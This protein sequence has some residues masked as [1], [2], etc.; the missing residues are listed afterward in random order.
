MLH[1]VHKSKR[2]SGCQQRKLKELKR[3][4]LQTVAGTMLKYLKRHED[5]QCSSAEPVIDMSQSSDV[6]MHSEGD[7]EVKIDGNVEESAAGE[8]LEMG[9]GAVE[10]GT[11]IAAVDLLVEQAEMDHTSMEEKGQEMHGLKRQRDTNADTNFNTAKDMKS[12]SNETNKDIDTL[13][14]V[15]F[16]KIPVTSHFRVAIMLK[17]S[18]SFQ[19]KDGP[20][21][22]VTRENKKSKGGVR[23][24]SKEWFYKEMPNGEKILRSWMVYSTISN[25]LYCFCCRLFAVATTKGISAF[26]TGFQK[27]WKLSPKVNDHENSEQHINCVEKWKTL[28]AGLKLEKTIDSETVRVMEAEKKRW[29]DMLHRLL[30]ITLFLAKQ[31][32]PFRGHR[33]SESSLNKG[34]FLELVEMLSK[35]DAVL[36]EHLMRLKQSTCKLQSAVTYLAPETQN[37]FI[38]IL[39]NQLKDKLVMEIKAAK[40]FAIMFD[41]TPDISQT[42]QMSE[43]IRYVKI[44][45]RTAEVKE[46]FLGF[47]QTKSKKAVDLS[48]DIVEKLQSDGLDI[49]MCRAQG[50]DNA[51][52]MAG[53]HGGVQAIL[54]GINKKLVFNGCVDH[55]LNLCGQH[56]FAENASCVTFFGTL[57]SMYAFFAAST[58]RWDVLIEHTAVSLKRLSTTRWS[59]H[60][61]AVKPVKENFDKFVVALEALCDQQENLDTRAAARSLLPAVCD[62]TFLCYLYFWYGVLHEV[63][64]AQVYLQGKALT[65]DRVIARLQALKFFLHD[66]CRPLVE[67][68]IEQALM[69]SDEHGIAVER[70]TRCK[71]MMPGERARDC[72]LPLKEENKR[73]MIECI[74]RFSTELEIRTKAMEELSVIFEAIQVKSLLFSSE[75]DLDVSIAN[76]TTV[77]DEVLKDALLVEILRLRRFLKAA[78]ID[79][80]KAKSW[81]VLDILNFIIEWD[82]ADSLPSLSLSLRLFLTICVSVASCERSFSKLKLIKSYLRS[83]MGQSRLTNLALL[84]IESEIAETMDFDETIDKF[85][86]V[87]ARKGKF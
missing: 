32:L 5:G 76:L 74:D 66:D 48:H 82:F 84:S 73:S 72:G 3:K 15:F 37:E 54:K 81:S 43:V 80:E 45:S 22:V 53:I 42:D 44:S 77:Y 59:A 51:A 10:Q 29:R 21:A 7:D 6:T 2:P 19:N 1:G 71:K 8:E 55:S 65:L 27:W 47:F 70:R 24:L 16:W 41:S 4:S 40:Y 58:H 23:Q 83:T 79:M 49:M 12:E 62:F 36:K 56:S 9:R 64:L 68:A 25:K 69:K 34:N 33:E 86:A 61:F 31:N 17:G 13:Q 39:A 38:D 60:Y 26:V 75:D 87:K 50:Y 14:D 78:T 35:Y 28:A 30:D 11:T 85:A 67:H 57:E 20:F 46:V 63:N 18:A 52:T